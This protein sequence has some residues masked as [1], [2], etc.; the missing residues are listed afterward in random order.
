M[1]K[2]GRADPAPL[3]SGALSAASLEAKKP[4]G[5]PYESADPAS[6]LIV[7]LSIASLE[8]KKPGGSPL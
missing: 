7:A 2:G 5:S 4:G 1:P 6:L 3:L 8:A